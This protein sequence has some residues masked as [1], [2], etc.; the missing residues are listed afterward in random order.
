[1]SLLK[2]LSFK[3]LLIHALA[4]ASPSKISGTHMAYTITKEPA[5]PTFI[6]STKLPDG[7][8]VINRFIHTAPVQKPSIRGLLLS[9]LPCKPHYILLQSSSGISV[10][11]LTNDQNW[12]PCFYFVLSWLATDSH[13]GLAIQL[14]N[15]HKPPINAFSD[16][17]QELAQ[18]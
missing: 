7:F 17:L 3:T 10:L 2:G 13:V 16:Y 8:S 14:T 12:A 6:P 4:T 18:H 1:M 9:C 15:V 5:S 11:L